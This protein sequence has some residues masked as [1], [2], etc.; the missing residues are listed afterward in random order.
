ML[1]NLPRGLTLAARRVN[2]RSLHQIRYLTLAT[3]PG[4]FHFVT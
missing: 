4:A 3:P 2:K 1:I